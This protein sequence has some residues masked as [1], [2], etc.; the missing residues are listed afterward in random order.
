M[1]DEQSCCL[2]CVFVDHRKSLSFLFEGWVVL[3]RACGRKGIARLCRIKML[4][5]GVFNVACESR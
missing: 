4:V 3:A 2:R 5:V 1:I